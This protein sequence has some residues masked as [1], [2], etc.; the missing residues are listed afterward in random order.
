MLVLFLLFGC[1]MYKQACK[2]RMYQETKLEVGRTAVGG[3]DQKS[4]ELPNLITGRGSQYLKKALEM[5]SLFEVSWFDRNGGT[6]CSTQLPFSYEK[7]RFFCAEGIWKIGSK[8]SLQ[9]TLNRRSWP[10]P[11][12]Y[13]SRNMT[14]STAIYTDE[15]YVSVYGDLAI[16][17]TAS[18]WNASHRSEF[19]LWWCTTWQSGTTPDP[20]INCQVFSLCEP[21]PSPVSLSANLWPERKR[22]S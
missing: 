2:P 7:A 15:G 12:Q 22:I 21:L 9:R 14:S 3:V 17:A 16:I 6:T 5:F 8:V 10:P 11:F 13:S 20:I 4:V 1:D 18:M 19:D